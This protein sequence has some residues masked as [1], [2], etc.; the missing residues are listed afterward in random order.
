MLDAVEDH[1][2]DLVLL[3]CL[4]QLLARGAKWLM[5]RLRK[6]L[7]D[8]QELQGCIRSF[9]A[10]RVGVAFKRETLQEIGNAALRDLLQGVDLRGVGQRLLLVAKSALMALHLLTE[11]REW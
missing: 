4:Q 3:Q 11:T 2:A 8:Q 7:E 6:L 10:F 9:N 1:G 5:V